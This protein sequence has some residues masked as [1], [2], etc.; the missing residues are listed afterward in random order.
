MSMDELAK[1]PSLGAKA[2]YQRRKAK[3]DK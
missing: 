2:A 1:E 3:G